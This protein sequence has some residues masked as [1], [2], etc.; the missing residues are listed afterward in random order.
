MFRLTPQAA[1]QIHS[2]A[3]ASN[4]AEMALR[5]AAKQGSDGE[6]EYVMGFDDEHENDT[7][8]SVEGV[9]V[10]ISRH[11]AALLAD[12]ELDYVELTPGEFNFIFVP[13]ASAP[14]AS[15]TSIPAPA[16]APKSTG[17]CGGGGCGGGCSGRSNA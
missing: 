11:S 16:P 7:A 12:I 3:L 6:I 14:A 15:A 5:V 2:A 13:S 10:V 17:G 1:T 9:R 8:L 4:A